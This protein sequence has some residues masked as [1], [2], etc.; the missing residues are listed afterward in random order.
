MELEIIK[1]AGLSEAQ[2][3]TYLALIENG[4]L[5]PAQI[6]AKTGETR[7][8]TYAILGK[9][10]EAGLVKKTLAKK[11]T[12][13]ASHP[14]ALE[15]IAEK[16]RRAAAKNEQTV[17]ANMS[18][19]LDIFYAHSEQPGVKTYLGYDGVKDIYRD[20][21][22]TGETVYLLRTTSDGEMFDFIMEYRYK[23]GKKGVKT[24]ALMPDSKAGREAMKDGTDEATLMD[25][26]IIPK[27]AYT[28]PV[29]IMAYGNKVTFVH[30]GDSTMSTIITSSAIAESIKQM[31]LL[32]REKYQANL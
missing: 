8:N 1:K 28:A 19:I 12:F 23:M 15:T 14:S 13:I 31:I 30:Y 32:L 24:I 21:L 17:K 3:K 16:K 9:L 6:A 29:T 20:I 10:E 26:V 11:Q 5:S 4:E 18:A 27:D 25:R 7:T 2:A 22:R